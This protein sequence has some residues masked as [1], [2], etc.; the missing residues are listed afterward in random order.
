MTKKKIYFFSTYRW[1][2]RRTIKLYNQVWVLGRKSEKFLKENIGNKLQVYI[3]PNFIDSPRERYTRE[4]L[5][6][7][8]SKYGK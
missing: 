2:L 6:Q 3:A 5:E 4:Q 1:L 7:I 8:M